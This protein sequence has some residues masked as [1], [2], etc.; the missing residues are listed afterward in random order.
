MSQY[1]ENMNLGDSLKI[2][3]PS[4]NLVY[5]SNGNFLIKLSKNAAPVSYNYRK[6][7]MIAGGTGIAPMLQII[8]EVLKNP[9]DKTQ[10]W[11]LFANQKENDILLREELDE[12]AKADHE[13]LSVWYTIETAEADWKY[14]VGF[15]NSEM[16]ENHLPP[17]GDDTLILMCGPPAMINLA[18]IPNLDKLGYSQ[19]SR[20]VY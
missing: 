19:S 8:R 18:C 15:V 12:A 6:L 1:L 13:Q 3:G 2:R 7:G 16:I 17:P 14:S 11:L 4:G 20:F 9:T 5:M 10:M